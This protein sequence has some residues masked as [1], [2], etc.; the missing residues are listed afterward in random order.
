VAAHSEALAHLR[1]GGDSLI[2]NCGY[3]HG[4]S[5]RE[6]VE[7]VKRVSGLDFPVTYGPRRPG[8]AT[9]VVASPALIMS[10]FGWKP[11]YDDLDGIVRSA[12][13]WEEALSGRNQRD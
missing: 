9:A 3:G 10:E 13:A 12:L 7:T 1:R 8:D 2:A 5:V 6:V 11:R 4:H